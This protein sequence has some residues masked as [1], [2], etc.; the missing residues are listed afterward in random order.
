MCCPDEPWISLFK[1]MCFVPL[2]RS[3][4]MPATVW[5]LVTWT[6]E[7]ARD[8]CHVQAPKRLPLVH[9]ILF[10]LMMMLRT[11]PPP[12]PRRW[13]RGISGSGWSWRASVE[14]ASTTGDTIFS[15][16][17]RGAWFD[18]PFQ[19]FFL[20][21]NLYVCKKR[22]YFLGSLRHCHGLA[23]AVVRLDWFG[24]CDVEEMNKAE[25]WAF[26]WR[27]ELRLISPMPVP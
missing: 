16:M 27:G 14:K 12:L 22:K 15:Q 5:W 4:Y 6:G 19:F 18:L 8:H 1:Q 3:M 13:R 9:I 25:G 17:S 2:F 23:L 7:A 24:L 10:L 26:L 11:P 20:L 21:F